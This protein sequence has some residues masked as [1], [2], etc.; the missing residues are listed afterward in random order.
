M[1]VYVIS[2]S[3]Y[4]K[5]GKAKNPNSRLKTLQTGNPGELWIVYQFH[6]PK[7][8]YQIESAL[9]HT[10]SHKKVNLEWFD[11]TAEDLLK[12]K[13]ECLKIETNLKLLDDL[14]V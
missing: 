10:F 1:Y 13:D 2:N 3:D 9:H 14:K 5:I 12:I 8:C 6:S 11:L 4:Y 7:Y